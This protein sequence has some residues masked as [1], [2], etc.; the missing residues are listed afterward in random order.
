LDK[1][2]LEFRR[3]LDI[4]MQRIEPD[5]RELE[6]L[7]EVL[8]EKHH[9][10]IL[11]LLR[12][13]EENTKATKA[14]IA[15]QQAAEKLYKE[16]TAI[17]VR[18]S[19]HRDKYIGDLKEC[20]QKSNLVIEKNNTLIKELER[21]ESEKPFLYQQHGSLKMEL[22]KK[23]KD[24]QTLKKEVEHKNSLLSTRKTEL[25]TLKDARKNLE[26]KIRN[27]KAETYDVIAISEKR[28]DK[29]EQKVISQDAGLQRRDTKLADL[30]SKLAEIEKSLV[31]KSALV[32]QLQKYIKK[33]D[34]KIS[35]LTTNYEFLTLTIVGIQIHN[36]FFEKIKPYRLQ[37]KKLVEMG[38]NA[39]HASSAYAD[40]L[41]YSP[42]LSLMTESIPVRQDINSFEQLY[43]CER[44]YV[45]ENRIKQLHDILK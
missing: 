24:L 29:L 5:F 18:Q 35:K 39:A 22:E 38:D 13:D 36:R 19:V 32:T 45:L 34:K 11:E 10:E 2:V 30:E 42:N 9:Q 14:I 17:L 27:V 1:L 3:S 25:E 33:K 16:N 41:L 43:D 40:A 44:E 21:R 6:K 12:Q 26:E 23:N 7:V 15:G 20:I 37:D 28:S 4:N 31:E 8:K